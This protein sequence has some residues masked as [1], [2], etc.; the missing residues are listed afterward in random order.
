VDSDLYD[1]DFCLWLEHTAEQIR[2]RDVNNL[3]WENLL[4]E[5]ESMGRSEKNALESKLIILL[6]HLLKWQF[7]PNKRTN[8]W[9]FTIT[10]HNL[11]INKAFKNSPSLK[12]YFDRVFAECYADARK[13]AS[14]ET[15][16]S[17]DTFPARCPFSYEEVIDCDRFFL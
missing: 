14:R 8:S 2:K 11:R 16:L 5:I 12:R 17:I 1:R 13:L 10:K 4:E 3:D 9:A 6:M 15:G 7:Q